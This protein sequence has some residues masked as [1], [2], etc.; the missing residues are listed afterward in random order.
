M[1]GGPTGDLTSL[2]RFKE[3]LAS[4]RDIPNFAEVSFHLDSHKTESAA[5][6]YIF[7]MG[8]G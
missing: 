6:P 7:R 5:D 1:F 4:I 8:P 2:L 3:L